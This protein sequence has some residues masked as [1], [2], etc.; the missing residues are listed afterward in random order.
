MKILKMF[1][2]LVLFP[3]FKP[4]LA[5]L[6]ETA[7]LSIE[8][9]GSG[10]EIELSGAYRSIGIRGVNGINLGTVQLASGAHVGSLDG[11][12]VPDI[13][14]PWTIGSY[15]GMHQTIK[16][17][18]IISDDGS[19]NVLLDFSGWSIAFGEFDDIYLGNGPDAGVASMTCAADC[20]D[21][22]TY[23]L[24]YLA[25]IPEDHISLL[26]GGNYH[27][28]L[29]GTISLPTQPHVVLP[30]L[31]FM[32]IDPGELID[33]C[34]PTGSYFGMELSPGFNLWAMIAPGTD[35]GMVIGKDQQSGGQEIGA[36]TTNTTSGEM[37]SAWFFF[38]NYGTL[39]ANNNI[40][41][42][43]RYSNDGVS[44]INDLNFAW[45]G[46]SISMGE[47]S[48]EDYVI[49]LNEFTG[50]YSFYYTA[51]VPADDPTGFGGIR[52]THIQSGNVILPDF[53]ADLSPYAR[54]MNIS[55]NSGGEVLWVPEF[56]TE[57]HEG[58]YTCEITSNASNGNAVLKPD[59]SS[60]SYISGA[61]YEGLDIFTY[62]VTDQNGLTD[63][64]A[65][66]VNV[67][68]S[69]A[70]LLDPLC[71]CKSLHPL[72]Q[73]TTVG[74]GQSMATNETLQTTFRG[75][76]KTSSGLTSGAKNRVE[77]CPG[78]SLDYS[79]TSSEGIA[80]CTNNNS[81]TAPSGKLV[82]GDKLICTNKPE[83]GDTDR[84]SIKNG[85]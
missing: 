22:D 56:A 64:A 48:V 68:Y 9:I 52:Y 62:S 36:S 84:F 45:N 79:V 78:T 81:V 67:F 3:V 23:T 7:N 44:E 25:K 19:G 58:V 82:S 11:T 70:C 21:G 40:N 73:V 50:N 27:L 37:T 59:C 61:S 6:P 29:A 83:G 1:L 51:I 17:I 31:T 33:Y 14:H 63:S 12:E 71:E 8:F 69:E 4:V 28:T 5:A 47:G 15:I 53:T 10:Y 46:T 74:G 80:R 76:I 43:S 72:K 57:N 65:V 2:L 13:D 20:S 32:D 18:N 54:N 38:G 49:T 24:R 85:L 39:Y 26:A 60:G 77:I 16:A 30:D 41:R 42:F 35:G 55:A 75:F 34:C 66:F